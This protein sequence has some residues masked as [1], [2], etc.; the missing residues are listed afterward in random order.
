MACKHTC[1]LAFE[2]W[3]RRPRQPWTWRHD[4]V[5]SRS[6]AAAASNTTKVSVS[7]CVLK[8]GQNSAAFAFLSCGF[9]S[10][11]A[12]ARDDSLCEFCGEHVPTTEHALWRRSH[13]EDGRPHKPIECLQQRLGWTRWP[14]RGNKQQQPQQQQQQQQQQR[15]RYDKAVTGHCLRVRTAVLDKKY[16]RS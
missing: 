15:Q 11:A 10:P 2:G 3:S 4:G 6:D 7:L 1:V 8:P 5:G 13:F 16:G 14:R 9:A 12:I